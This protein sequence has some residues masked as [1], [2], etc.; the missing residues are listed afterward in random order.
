MPVLGRLWL[1]QNRWL[2]LG[3]A[4]LQ[5]AFLYLLYLGPLNTQIPLFWGAFF[6]AFALYLGLAWSMASRPAGSLGL[7]L[8]LALLFRCTLLWSPP[9]LSDDIFRYLWDG[10]VQQA[11]IN[12]YRY[13][14]SD[15][16]LEPLRDQYYAAINHK[17]LPTIYPPLSQ[18]FFRL[19]A[20]VHPSPTA[21]KI[22]LTLVEM[23]LVLILPAILSQRRQDRRRVLIY[24]WNPLPIIE[25]AGSGHSDSLGVFL[26]FLALYCLGG[27]RP[28]RATAALAAAFLSKF[29]PIMLV[30]LFWRQ[31]GPAAGRS[32]M[33][34]WFSLRRRL[35]L[36]WFPCL[37]GLGFLYFVQ[38]DVQLFAGLQTYLMKWRFNDAFFSVLYNLLRN[39]DLAVDDGA[40][41]Q[42]K[43]IC[44]ALL[45][46]VIV[47]TLWRCD[48]FYQAAFAVLGTYLL[49]SPVLYPWYLLWILPFLSF[50]PRPSWMLFSGLVFLA[51]AVL[52]AYSRNGLWLEPAW[53]K[54]AQYLPFFSLAVLENIRRVQRRGRSDTA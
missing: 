35:A 54:W 44:S 22:G 51:Y 23:G 39:P 52:I 47:W 25:I 8:T 34:R 28:A 18:L 20:S 49:L 13:A 32:F 21:V 36:M 6:A 50:F 30:P 41:A 19:A 40:L 24:A 16:H 38:T 33:H 2:L 14:P 27:H 9:T 1:A 43:Y 7:I 29:L 42:T 46:L 31:L 45:L 37:A 53:V 12:P 26:L 15:L 10:R 3:G 11:G 17:E 5:C 48:D 4:V